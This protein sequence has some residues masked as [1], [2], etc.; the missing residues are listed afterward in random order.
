MSQSPVDQS[1]I[2]APVLPAALL[3]AMDAPQRIISPAMA[4]ATEH[5][6]LPPPLGPPTL[7]NLA[8]AFNT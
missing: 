3:A 1:A 5:T 4:G 8:C 6:G 2:G 7:L